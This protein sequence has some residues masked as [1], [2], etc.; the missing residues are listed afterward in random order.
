MP[1]RD[2]AGHDHLRALLVGAVLRGTLPPSLIFSGPEGVGKHTTAVA[3]A[4]FVNCQHRGVPEG[5]LEPPAL[6]GPSD[7]APQATSADGPIDACGTCQ[8]CRRI[9]R[10]VH[11]DVLYVEPGD[12]GAIKIEQIRDVVERSGYRPFE[13][14]RRVVIVDQAEQI[15]VA[16][17]DALLKTLEEPP[18]ATTF[19]LVTAHPAMLLPTVLS[20]CQRLRF[21]PLTPADVAV[22]LMRCHDYT[23]AEAVTAASFSDGSIGRSLEGG[24]EEFADARGAALQ[25]LEIVAGGPAPARRI[26]GAAGMP[27]TAKADRQALA[28]SLRA[29]GGLLRD[30]GALGARADP[31][32]IANA[33]LGRTLEKLVPAYDRDRVLR[34]FTAIDRALDA[35]ERNGS[36]K[37]VADW[38]SF[39]I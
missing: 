29:L 1:F 36:P 21:G 31:R 37:I 39:Q 20:R 25:L 6:F 27:G 17:Q 10:R 34:S 38:V 30:L 12:T 8:A 15:V 16:A 4:Q 24:S 14:R 3:L 23:E 18:N 9:A 5:R 2:I 35:L 19:V 7:V 32:T 33:D 11:A 28:R 22:I 26:Q 13:G